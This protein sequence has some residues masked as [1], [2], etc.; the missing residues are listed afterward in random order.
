MKQAKQKHW[1]LIVNVWEIFALSSIQFRN[2]DCLHRRID[3]SPNTLYWTIKTLFHLVYAICI[4][5]LR[6]WK[7]SFILCIV[8]NYTNN[9]SD[10]LVPTMIYLL[11]HHWFITAVCSSASSHF[12][13]FVNITSSICL[14]V[15]IF[16]QFLSQTLQFETFSQNQFLLMKRLSVE[17]CPSF[18]VNT[19]PNIQTVW[20]RIFLVD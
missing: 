13:N 5:K 14:F 9:R 2:H 15:C 20:H 8:C 18:M 3:I 19:Y 10:A 4:I 1:L 16:L 11:L 17:T 6:L 12:S 7:H